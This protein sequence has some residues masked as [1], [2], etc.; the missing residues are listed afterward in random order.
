MIGTENGGRSARIKEE[1][2]SAY[3]NREVI[4]R[5]SLMQAVGPTDEWCAEA[6]LP[7]D[8]DSIDRNRLLEAARRHVIGRVMNENAGQ[9]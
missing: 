8:Y 2:V 6:Y 1:W 5:F 9:L 3:R 4:D 7:T